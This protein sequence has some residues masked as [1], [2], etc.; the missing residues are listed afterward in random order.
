MTYQ[1]KLDKLIKLIQ[2]SSKRI[3]TVVT[4]P[5]MVKPTNTGV[6][7]CLLPPDVEFDTW[8]SPEYVFTLWLITGRMW[9]QA[10]ASLELLET[11]EELTH[12]HLNM[13]YA[14]AATFAIENM[15]ELAGYEIKL[16]PLDLGE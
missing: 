16:K 11:I 14:R 15:G 6:Y 10:K 3:K 12:N 13:D 7:A 2:D 1:S 5:T 9:T 4:D 8:E